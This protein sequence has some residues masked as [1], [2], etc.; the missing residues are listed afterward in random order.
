MMEAYEHMKQILKQGGPLSE[1][2][3]E[4]PYVPGKVRTKIYSQTITAT[5][6]TAEAFFLTTAI[7][8]PEEEEVSGMRR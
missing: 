2:H 1:S 4:V 3:G 8:S 7:A 5:T 6:S